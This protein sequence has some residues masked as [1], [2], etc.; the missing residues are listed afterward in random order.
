MTLKYEDYS[1]F[2][3]DHANTLVKNLKA[4]DGGSI[5]FMSDDNKKWNRQESI[6]NVEVAPATRGDLITITTAEGKVYTGQGGFSKGNMQTVNTASARGIG[7]EINNGN[8]GNLNNLLTTYRN[9]SNLSSL[10]NDLNRAMP[11]N[12]PNTTV[13]MPTSSGKLVSM[14]LPIA[15]DNKGVDININGKN[16]RLYL[17]KLA[18]GNYTIVS[19]DPTKF[20]KKNGYTSYGDVVQMP[21]QYTRKN[22]YSVTE[23]AKTSFPNLTEAKNA[24]AFIVGDAKGDFQGIPTGYRKVTKQEAMAIGNNSD[25]FPTENE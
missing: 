11:K 22:R 9:T 25:L 8:T 3:T 24:L 21:V 7:F 15:I 20:S 18:E 4:P 16:R 1:K 5:S 2:L 10:G 14:D 6:T 19:A 17:A 12:Y 23:G 13:Y